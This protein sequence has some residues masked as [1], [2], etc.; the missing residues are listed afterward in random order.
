MP[1]H[2]RDCHRSE[3]TNL[4][5][6]HNLFSADSTDKRLMPAETFAE[7]HLISTAFRV[8]LRQKAL[9]QQCI[10]SAVTHICTP[11]P[12]ESLLLGASNACCTLLTLLP[13][14]GTEPL[15]TAQQQLCWDRLEPG[16]GGS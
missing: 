15:T 14:S 9:C 1:A 4:C 3:H 16:S 11:V 13:P 12:G 10:F 8:T 2:P 6:L 7:S 5:V